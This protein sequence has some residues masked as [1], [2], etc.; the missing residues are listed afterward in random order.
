MTQSLQRRTFLKGAAATF[1]AGLLPYGLVNATANTAFQQKGVAEAIAA[2]L[3]T[4]NIQDNPALKIKAPD[5]AENGAVVPVTVQTEL[6]DVES[7]TLLATGNNQPLIGTFTLGAGAI[8]NV[9]ARIK[10]AKTSDIVVIA[11]VGN[12]LYCNTKNV[13]VTIGGCGG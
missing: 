9:S 12:T 11:K 5:I 3:G 13:K 2:A 4:G 1:A 8:A 6:A 10:M 7:I